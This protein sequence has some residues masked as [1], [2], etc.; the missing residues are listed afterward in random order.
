MDETIE[1]YRQGAE[2]HGSGARPPLPERLVLPIEQHSFDHD[3]QIRSQRAATA[4]TTK[5]VVTTFGE[6]DM[7][8]LL[9]VVSCVGAH[10]PR[11]H[12]SEDDAV[13]ERKLLGGRETG[14]C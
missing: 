5:Y 7:D 14:V 3:K 6:A 4:K 8:R 2:A 11:S 9:E 1:L 10:T 12:D 13:Q